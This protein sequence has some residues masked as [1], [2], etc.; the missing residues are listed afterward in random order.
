M[1][2]NT[3]SEIRRPNGITVNTVNPTN[4]DFFYQAQIRARILQMM[5]AAKKIMITR[6]SSLIP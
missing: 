5:H 6:I 3:G 1:T 4:I 2:L